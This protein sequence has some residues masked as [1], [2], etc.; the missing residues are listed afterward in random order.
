MEMTSTPGS[1]K[2]TER[3][4]GHRRVIDRRRVPNLPV[5]VALRQVLRTGNRD[6]GHSVWSPD[7]RT[8]AL[9]SHRGL[10]S[11]WDIEANRL[12][13]T[14]DR[15][16]GVLQGM[17]WSPDSKVVAVPQGRTIQLWN[18]NSGKLRRVLRGHTDTIHDVVWSPDGHTL[19]SS[20]WDRTIRVWDVRSGSVL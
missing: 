20:A 2:A 15:H 18:R 7:G 8:L 5:G 13:R 4:R 10:I 6:I 3:P 12:G 14:L 11:L 1:I 9:V 19:A 17:A 16:G